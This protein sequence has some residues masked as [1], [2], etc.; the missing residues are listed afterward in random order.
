[1]PMNRQLYPPNWKEISHDIRFELAQ[2]QCQCTGECGLHRTH[3][4]PRRCVER[5]GEP[6]KWARGR[7]V[8]TVAHLCHEPSCRDETHVKAM[9][10][11][12]HRRYDHALH[13]HHAKETRTRRVRRPACGTLETEA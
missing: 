11:R 10:Q 4:A 9:C 13:Q 5:H 2:G 7:I 1:M 8:L 6:A 12:C 3:P